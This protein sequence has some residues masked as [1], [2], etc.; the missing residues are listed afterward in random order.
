MLTFLGLINYVQEDCHRTHLVELLSFFVE[1][2]FFPAY[3]G[4]ENAEAEE[5]ESLG[6]VL[7]SA[8]PL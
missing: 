3:K 6:Q 4:G 7:P 2:N 8:V 5:K 1:I